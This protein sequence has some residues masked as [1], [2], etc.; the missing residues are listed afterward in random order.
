MFL[1]CPRIADGFKIFFQQRVVTIQ[2]KREV[3]ETEQFEILSLMNV[4][5]EKNMN[6]SFRKRTEMKVPSNAKQ[7]KMT[8]FLCRLHQIQLRAHYDSL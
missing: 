2:M 1:L 7:T 5:G 3:K 4:R 6:C 8:P